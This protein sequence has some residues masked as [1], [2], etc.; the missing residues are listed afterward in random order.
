MLNYETLLS[1][2]YF[3]ILLGGQFVIFVEKVLLIVILEFLYSA[4]YLDKKK[5]KKV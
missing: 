5:K 4:T 3:L 2:I 1:F